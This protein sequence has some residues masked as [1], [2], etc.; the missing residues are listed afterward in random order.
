MTNDTWRAT[1]KIDGLRLAAVDGESKE[2][3][4][5]EALRYLSQY[6]EEFEDDTFNRTKLEFKIWKK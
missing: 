6:L 4:T 5:R 1:L 2:W 3:V